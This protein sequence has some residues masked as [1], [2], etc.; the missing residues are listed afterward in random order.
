M[1][2]PALDSPMLWQRERM[3]RYKDVLLERSTPR[4]K[5][6]HFEEFFRSAKGEGPDV[7]VGGSG[8]ACLYCIKHFAFEL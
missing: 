4:I 1:R 3:K 2:M 8:I 5:G 6:S 7:F